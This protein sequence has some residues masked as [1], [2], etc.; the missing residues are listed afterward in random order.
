MALIDPPHL[1]RPHVSLDI[2]TVR[3]PDGS[4]GGWR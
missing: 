4:T 2:D 1:H 3:F